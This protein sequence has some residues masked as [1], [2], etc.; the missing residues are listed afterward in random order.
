MVKY[1]TS[2]S[3]PV[4]FVNVPDNLVILD[5]SSQKVEAKVKATG[6]NILRQKLSNRFVPLELDVSNMRLTQKEK[7][8]AFLLSRTE[9]GEIRSRLLLGMDLVDLQP[10]T[11][12]LHVDQFA[13]RKVPVGFKAELA[14]EQQFILADDI[15]LARF[16]YSKW[17]IECY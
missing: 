5:G 3:C 4:S 16:G 2:L 11:I 7:S 15:G 14:F 6:F 17:P 1:V 10:D 8:M 13:T 9:M 12:F